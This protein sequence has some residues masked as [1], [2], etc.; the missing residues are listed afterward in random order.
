[1]LY[2]LLVC[3]RM[4]DAPEALP[5]SEVA[6]CRE[7]RVEVWLDRAS[8]SVADA[9][10]QQEGVSV[11]VLCERCANSAVQQVEALGGTIDWHS[12]SPD[13]LRDSF[14]RRMQVQRRQRP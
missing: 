3:A 9:R 4:Q 14:E 5:G 1:M 11:V 13:Q 6:L 10:A 2:V 12:P 8:R 7:C